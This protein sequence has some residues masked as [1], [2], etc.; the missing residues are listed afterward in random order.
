MIQRAFRAAN[1][2]LLRPWANEA[3]RFLA[4]KFR[5]EQ[6]IVV[7][8]WLRRA[9]NSPTLT[10]WAS[11]AARSLNL[12]LV[13]PLALRQFQPEEVVVWQLFASI[14]TLQLLLDLGLTPTFARLIAFAMGGATSFGDFRKIQ[15]R[16]DAAGA[17]PNWAG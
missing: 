2:R 17:Q 8:A 16:P 7:K 11:F 4:S 13:L 1:R 12:I 15:S 3:K 14:M 5:V 9:W 6:T 10:T